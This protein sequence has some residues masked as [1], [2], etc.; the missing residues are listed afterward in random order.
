MNSPEDANND[1]NEHCFQRVDNVPSIVR[2]A[3]LKGS[4]GDDEAALR[5]HDIDAFCY[6][7]SNDDEDDDTISECDEREES[8]SKDAEVLPP[9]NDKND[10]SRLL[11][12]ITKLIPMEKAEILYQNKF[13]TTIQDD[14]G[15]K[16][17]NFRRLWYKFPLDFQSYMKKSNGIETVMIKPRPSTDFKHLLRLISHMRDNI[18]PC[19]NGSTIMK[20]A[21]FERTF[22]RKHNIKQ[23]EIDNIGSAFGLKWVNNSGTDAVIRLTKEHSIAHQAVQLAPSQRD[24]SRLLEVV[25]C[26]MPLKEAKIL[27]EAKFMTSIQSDYGVPAYE[28]FAKFTKFFHMYDKKQA[29]KLGYKGGKTVSPIIKEGDKMLSDC[30]PTSERKRER[31]EVEEAGHQHENIFSQVSFS[32]VNNEDEEEAFT[33]ELNSHRTSW[34]N[35]TATP[36]QQ[37]NANANYKAKVS[38]ITEPFS[39]I[40]LASEQQLSDEESPEENQVPLQAMIPQGRMNNDETTQISTQGPNL[41]DDIISYATQSA[42]A[43]ALTVEKETYSG[44]VPPVPLCKKTE[45]FRAGSEAANMYNY[46]FQSNSQKKALLQSKNSVLFGESVIKEGLQS[47]DY[48]L[49]GKILETKDT[50]GEDNCHNNEYDEDS[51]VFLNVSNPFCLVCVGVQGAGK[52]HSMNVVLENCLTQVP[53]PSQQPITCVRRPM[54]GLVLHYDQSVNNV[55]EAT[56]LHAV[57]R[58]MDNLFGLKQQGVKG[59]QRLVVL[60]SPSFYHQRKQ[61]YKDAG[62]EVRPLLFRWTSL[63]AEQLKKLMRLSDKDAQLYVSVMLDLLRE[64]QREMKMPSFASFLEEVTRVCNLQAQGGPLK[65]RLQLLQSVVLESK[66]NADLAKEGLAAEGLVELLASGTLVVADLT[67]PMLS[68]DEANGIFQVLLEQFRNCHVPGGVGKV[69][70]FDEAHKYLSGT[71]GGGEGG[72]KDLRSYSEHSTSDAT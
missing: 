28:A 48:G 30:I 13:N 52:S 42:A 22:G 53:L 16:S 36:A 21:D 20:C 40:S 3:A 9:V 34:Y 47:K 54:C 2:L 29:K 44:H 25:S 31:I 15:V 62:F 51:N 35:E 38:D 57:S 14:Y 18:I 5:F 69:V 8:V 65:Q 63:G 10:P 26:T 11:A 46:F 37:T 1:G 66:L 27:Y 61:F 70:A 4:N 55:C 43:A 33:S 59:V 32:D 17:N 58:R 19:D 72:G 67:D 24:P 49:F 60:V 45:D 41:C 71:G 64:Y 7:T 23:N 39:A 68:S 56:G 50:S 6:N 12:V